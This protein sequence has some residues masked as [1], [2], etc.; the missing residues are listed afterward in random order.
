[1]RNGKQPDRLSFLEHGNRMKG[2]RNGRG[3]ERNGREKEREMEE[4]KKMEERKRNGKVSS[5]LSH[6]FMIDTPHVVHFHS[7]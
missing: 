7:F 3:K 1:M 2:E 4:R 6:L 5:H